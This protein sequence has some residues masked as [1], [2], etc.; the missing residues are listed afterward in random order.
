GQPCVIPHFPQAARK[1]EK[2]DAKDDSKGQRASDQRSS[3]T[4][5]QE[6]R[7]HEHGS[8]RCDGRSGERL[9]DGREEIQRVKR[10][11]FERKDKRGIQDQ[12]VGDRVRTS[13]TKRPPLTT[14]EECHPARSPI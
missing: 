8:E 6:A 5:L 11:L 10:R 9:R 1:Q 3:R 7:R 13:S 4:V 2:T 14:P 12:G